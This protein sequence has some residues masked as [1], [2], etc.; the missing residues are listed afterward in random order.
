MLNLNN[1]N[2]LHKINP[3]QK[4]MAIIELLPILVIFTLIIN[5]AFGFFGVIHTGILNSIAC[6]NYAFD[7]FN[8]RSSLFYFRDNDLPINPFYYKMGSRFHSIVSEKSPTGS[9]IFFATGREVSITGI[10]DFQG[11]S[12]AFH[13]N[14]NSELM[15]LS[16]K[17][18]G[19][20]Y[21]GEGSNPVWIK[22]MCGICITAKCGG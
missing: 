17:K 8:N 1:I 7:T 14:E 13:N 20:R 9:I 19:D 22:S 12:E 15:K 11:E 18:A 10:S 16:Q 21:D 3:C 4:G 6:R 2:N 5:F